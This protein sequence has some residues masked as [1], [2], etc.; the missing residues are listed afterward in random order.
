MKYDSNWDQGVAAFELHAHEAVRADSAFTY[1][2]TIHEN[3]QLRL[4]DL[5][6]NVPSNFA[7]GTYK[8]ERALFD[9]MVVSNLFSVLQEALGF[10]KDHP[11]NRNY[12][13]RAA[14]VLG[15]IYQIIHNVEQSA[16]S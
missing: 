5:I 2:N 15:A 12:L 7:Q 16:E 13:A 11:K 9:L 8:Y 14:C 1:L 6:R 3:Y 4:N 10:V